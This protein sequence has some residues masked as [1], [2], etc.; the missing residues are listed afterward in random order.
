MAER[1]GE[2]VPTGGGDPIPL[3]KRKLMIGRRSICDIALN[4]PNV[5]SRHCEL[6]LLNGYWQLRDLGSTNGVKVNGERCD[7]KFLIPGDRV[8]IAKHSFTIEYEADPSA[9]LPEE[10]EDI[11]SKSLMEKAGLSRGTS[12]TRRPR[13][14]RA[15]EVPTP[16]S[17]QQPQSVNRR[18]AEGHPPGKPRSDDDAAL[19]YL[20][21]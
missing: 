20:N 17:V 16:P 4:F 3:L 7:Q 8:T 6:E 13:P 21:D 5:S 18:P 19:D 14:P 12:G 2:L 10:D 9:P 15:S 11:F 1:L